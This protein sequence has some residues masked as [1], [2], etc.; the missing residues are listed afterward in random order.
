MISNYNIDNLIITQNYSNEKRIIKLNNS[1]KETK[2]IQLIF[3]IGTIKI[4]VFMFTTSLSS[5]HWIIP[6]MDDYGMTHFEVFVNGILSGYV[7]MI[8][9]KNKIPLKDKIICLGLNKTATSSIS[10]SLNLIG[11]N[12]YP[13]TNQT[14]EGFGDKFFSSNV[15]SYI[16]FMEN[17]KYT[18]FKDIPLSCTEISKKII[19]YSPES[20]FI[21]SVRSNPEKW[22]NSVKRFWHEWFK[23]DNLDIYRGTMKVKFL[24][25]HIDKPI[26][27]YGY[28][29]GLFE[30]W[31]LDKFEGN[32]N[33]KLYQYYITHNNEIRSE[34]RK[35]SCNWIEVDASKEGEF[36]RL[37]DFLGVYNTEEN[38]VHVNKS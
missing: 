10:K 1:S 32:I 36:K 12:T 22:V 8:K 25:P 34:L 26:N 19:R 38:F 5:N 21:L 9:Q 33:E 15:G 29:S 31:N 18:F 27:Y 11:F 3:Y 30:S 23:N 24:G 2:D 14:H 35:Y 16:D 13:S 17:T 7:H 6:D 20:K 37:T 28:L 4:P